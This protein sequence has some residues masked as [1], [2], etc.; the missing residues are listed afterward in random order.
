MDI[1]LKYFPDLTEQQ[2]AR[3]EKLYPFYRHWNSLI[4]LISRND[5]E[6]LYERH[7]LYSLSIAKAINFQPLQTVLD[8]GTGGG[9]PGIPLAILFPQTKFLLVDSIGKKIKVVKELIHVLEL[10]NVIA[11]QSR[12][13]DLTNKYD[14]IISRAVAT[15]PKF[16]NLVKDKL[17]N[18]G[19]Y[20]SNGLYYFKGGD[21]SNEIKAFKNTTI[22]H[23][24]DFF[25]EP[26]FET[27][28]IIFIPPGRL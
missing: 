19:T 15:L 24:T 25:K 16:A 26:F 23:L 4:N 7:V 22:Y 8:V 18:S 6:N 20:T 1:I 2:K 11:V 27:K 28:L 3:F 13:E 5:I 9:F 14:V 17:S 10:K 21:I 12:V